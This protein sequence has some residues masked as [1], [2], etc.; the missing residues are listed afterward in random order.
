MNLSFASRHTYRA[1]FKNLSTC[2]SVSRHSG[3]QKIPGDPPWNNMVEQ[4]NRSPGFWPAE[5]MFKINNRRTTSIFGRPVPWL[6]SKKGQLWMFLLNCPYLC[7]CFFKLLSQMFIFTIYNRFWWLFT[8][9]LPW[10][11]W[12]FFLLPR[13]VSQRG[14]KTPARC[15]PVSPPRYDPAPGRWGLFVYRFVYLIDVQNNNKVACYHTYVYK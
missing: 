4:F 9:S 8:M 3:T 2:I 11:T 7:Q 1:W 12:I 15:G 10:F 5:S 13:W 6:S 14:A